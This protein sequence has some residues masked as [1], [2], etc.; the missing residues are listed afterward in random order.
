MTDTDAYDLVVLGAGPAGYVVESPLLAHVASKEAEIA[1]EHIAGL[2]P[3]ARIDEYAI[4]SGV[5]TEPQ[6]AGFGLTEAAAQEQ[7]VEYLKSVFPYRGIGKAVAA[8]NPEGL[9][10]V[11]FD[12]GTKE[13]LGVHLAGLEAT[14]LVHEILLARSAELL[15]Q[16]VASM[17]HA[18][19][20]LS[21]GVMEAMRGVDGSAIH[22]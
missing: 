16:D 8:G 7:G 9:V 14:E 10:K 21:E 22:A 2:E 17:V 5:Y 6:I 3:E 1:V 11:V 12:P 15:P 13:I 20:T 4:P 18:H 19:P